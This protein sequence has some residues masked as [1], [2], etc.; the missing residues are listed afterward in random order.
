MR[1]RKLICLSAL[2]LALVACSTA[3]RAMDVQFVS[4][5][6]VTGHIRVDSVVLR[7]SVF[8]RER[9]DTVFYTK[10]RTVYK[11]RLKVD[12]VVRCDT[13]FRDRE[14]V[15]EKVRESNEKRGLVWIVPLVA[16]LLF[17]LWR[18]GLLSAMWKLILKGVELC[19]RI[20]HLK[21]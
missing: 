8:I 16:L 3:E 5:N 2:L 19:K 15:V 7:D 14:V 20:F 17:L 6:N 4:Q 21:E 12:T 13:L 18:T 10:Y 11:E 9:S 1:K